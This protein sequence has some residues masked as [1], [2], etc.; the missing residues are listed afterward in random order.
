MQQI[1]QLENPTGQLCKNESLW[2]III[3]TNIYKNNSSYNSKTLIKK[4][5]LHRYT[6]LLTTG[7]AV[8]Y[9][10]DR[11]E[12]LLPRRPRRVEVSSSSSSSSSSPRS[13]S[14]RW[15]KTPG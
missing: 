5:N 8:E 12:A 1:C 10:R 6:T 13:T 7:R 15:T 2:E 14:P 4:Q 11:W 9:G 3:V